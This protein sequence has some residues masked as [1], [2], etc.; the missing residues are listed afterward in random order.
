MKRLIVGID[1][2]LNCGLAAFTLDG[3][4]VII[5]SR[6]NWTLSSL[7]QTITQLGE[8]T[9][10][11]SDVTPAPE[12]AEKISK[13]LNAVLFTPLISM[14]TDEKHQ[15]AQAYEKRYGLDLKNNHEVDA[16]AAA[17]KAYQ[18]YKNK[19]E[20]V[21]AKIKKIGLNISV[22]D[23]KDLLVRG[24]N[25]E[26]AIRLLSSA[27]EVKTPRIVKRTIPRE[28]RMKSLIENLK[29]RLT[30]E[31]QKSKRLTSANRELRLKIKASES[32][33]SALKE[34]IEAIR[35]EQSAQVKQGREFQLLLEEVKALKIKLS[36]YSAALETYRQQFDQLQRLRDLETQGGSILLKPVEAFTKNGLEK[37]VRLYEI[38][39]GDSLFLLDPSGG[40]T[41]TAEFLVKRGVKTIIVRGAMSHQAQEVFA[42]YSVPV[43]P[44][45]KLK[46]EWIEGLPHADSESLKRAAKEVEEKQASRSLEDLKTIV[47][48]HR[49]ELE[50]QKRSL[51]MD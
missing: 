8:P 24:H 18:H 31:K 9:I 47:E 23:A 39:A 28:E 13:K 4:P 19:F 15:L 14:G 32:A 51:N 35:S 41:A 33:A 6:R 11:S 7:I 16:L 36:E 43:I 17:A 21:E 5:D 27:G 38:K 42:E 37:A 30:L 45:E 46:V 25:I 26:R 34:K 44:A 20:Q 22:D 2:G 1:P 40:G 50:G 29:E 48:E 10:V 3:A 49:K 12:F